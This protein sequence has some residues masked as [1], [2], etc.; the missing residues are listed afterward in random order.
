MS[1]CIANL[2]WTWARWER[3][4]LYLREVNLYGG[5]VDART[6]HTFPHSHISLPTTLPALFDVCV[7][8]FR[9]IL[10]YIFAF[11]LPHKFWNEVLAARWVTLRMHWEVS[12]VMPAWLW[13][14]IDVNKHQ[15]VSH[16]PWH[17]VIT[18]AVMY[19]I[20]NKCALWRTDSFSQMIRRLQSSQPWRWKNS[21]TDGAL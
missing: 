4:G 5:S 8:V 20:S 11:P 10:V 7:S 19:W 13:V 17:L 15:T 21:I 12:K 9:Y 18:V 1:D 3:L 16:S 6:L 14:W 2:W